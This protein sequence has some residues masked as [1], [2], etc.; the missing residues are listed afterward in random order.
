[1]SFCNFTNYIADVTARYKNETA[2]LINMLNNSQVQFYSA[3]IVAPLSF[4]C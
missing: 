3:Y 2:N 1:M 4:S